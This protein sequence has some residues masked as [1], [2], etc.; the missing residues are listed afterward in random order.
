MFART[1][2]TEPTAAEVLLIRTIGIRDLALGLGTVAAAR[3]GDEGDIRRWLAAGLASDSLDAAASVASLPAIGK[4]DSCGAET[5]MH[6]GVF[7]APWT[8][9]VRFWRAAMMFGE[10]G[11]TMS[12]GRQLA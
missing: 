12:S 8:P 11:P 10:S 5:Y 7:R 6:A 3:S 2:R 1:R 9:D 4:R